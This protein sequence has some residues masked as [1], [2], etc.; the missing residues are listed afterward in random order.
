MERDPGDLK[1]GRGLSSSPT[2]TA[3]ALGKS[4]GNSLCCGLGQGM[5]LLG[6]YPVRM[7]TN[8]NKVCLA[9]LFQLGEKSDEVMDKN[10]EPGSMQPWASMVQATTATSSVLTPYGSWARTVLLLIRMGAGSHSCSSQQTAA[11]LP[12]PRGLFFPQTTLPLTHVPWL[13][14]LPLGLTNTCPALGFEEG[15]TAKLMA[16]S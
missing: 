11:T 10:Q 15:A 16:A 7:T 2:R 12:H 8:E 9:Y 1:S 13:I 6:L 14:P 5:S 4:L 3:V